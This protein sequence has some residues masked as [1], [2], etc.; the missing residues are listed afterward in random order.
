[1]YPCKVKKSLISEIN[2]RNKQNTLTVNKYFFCKPVSFKT[3][4]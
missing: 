1:M 2:S 3:K 4:R